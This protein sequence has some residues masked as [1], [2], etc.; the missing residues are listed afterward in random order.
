[1][2][3]NQKSRG[4][5]PF[6]IVAASL[7]IL[8][9]APILAG[10]V[11]ELVWAF[12]VPPSRP[13]AGTLVAG[14]DGYFWGTTEEGGARGQGT[15]YKVRADGSDWRSIVSFDYNNPNHRGYDPR[16][17]LMSD[18]VDFLWGTTN[19]GGANDSGTIFKVRAS[20]GELIKVLD[21][22]R[23]GPTNTGA[24]C[25]AELYN[26]GA[27]YF[28]GTTREG[29]A[30][31]DGTIFKVNANTGLLTNLVQ[32]NRN[33]AIHNGA[34]PRA[35]LVS[36]GAGYLW[37]T[38]TLG[39][40]FNAGTVFK[41]N[42]STGILTTAV[43]FSG[44]GATN[45]GRI[46]IAGLI[47]DGAGFLWGTTT[48]GG[49]NEMGT[50]FKVNASTGA[51]STVAEF[52]PPLGAPNIAPQPN[53]RLI[54][55]GAGWFR[56]TTT[57][58]G[59]LALGTLFAVNATTGELA[60]LFEFTGEGLANRGSRP[61][62][63]LVSVG[64]GS[65]LGTTQ[66]GGAHG[67]GTVFRVEQSTGALTTLLE[68]NDAGRTVKGDSPYVGLIN[69]GAGSLWGTT[70]LGG[71]G[72]GTIF[73]V[74]EATGEVRTVV[75][76]TG[77]G[78]ANRGSEP[79]AMLVG[80]GAGYLWGTTSE[81]G[82]SESG[83]IFKIHASTGLMTTVLEFTGNGPANRG[84]RP[85]GELAG[86]GMGFFW[87]TTFTGGANGSGTVF[88]VHAISGTLSTL[89]D[90]NNA[91]GNNR[92][93]EPYAG[94]VHDDL[95]FFWGTTNRGGVSNEGTIFKVNANTGAITTVVD[96]TGNG[97]ILKGGEPR[98][99]LASDGLGFFWGTTSEGGASD[100]GT[101]FKV[102][103]STGE[104]S[105]VVEFT[106]MNGVA[107][108]GEP[109]AG[110]IGD[111]AGFLWGTTWKGG[112][113]D[114]GTV[115][116]VNVV[117]GAFTTVVELTGSG[118]QANSGY[119]PGYGS[120]LRHSD[121]SFYGTTQA[122]GPENGGTVFRLRFGP[123]PV[124]LAA[125]VLGATTATLHGTINPNGNF[126]TAWFE[127]GTNPVLAT[128][129]TV[130]AGTTTNGTIPEA[131]STLL[132]GLS[133]GITYYYRVVGGN[134]ENAQPQ[135]G[136]IRSFTLPGI[137]PLQ[138]WR[139][140]HF[141]TTANVGAAANLADWDGDNVT[142]LIEFALGM[143]P[144]QNST[145]L[146]PTGKVI[147]GDFVLTVIQPPGVNGIIYGAEW[148]TTLLPASWFPASNTA[149]PPQYT[150]RLPIGAAGKGFL[151]LKVT[152]Q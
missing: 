146:L 128:F 152:A 52:I 25:R 70:Q 19:R 81:G 51:L 28:W 85:I 60:T 15:V 95:G 132:S 98:A 17:A 136:A 43:E 66:L 6:F 5:V 2:K 29:G 107:K 149:T 125:D 93:S 116:K 8:F 138:A 82:A 102:N 35:G 86:D 68:F 63:G 139:L 75:E 74:I 26:D 13:S 67:N 22:N 121:G 126:S 113:H 114:S 91:I 133:S 124:T 14:P 129:F 54:S 103:A 71:R 145:G 24:H 109:R 23:N 38:T 30:S 12:G 53:A 101:V 56:G 9:Q 84:A 72:Y 61:L 50:V 73:K 115:F 57:W 134:A 83:T 119:L 122:G 10:P 48:S 148:S 42:A 117:S 64:D 100:L 49:T 104:M 32:F 94:L 46:P 118:N 33:E 36:D 112:S 40:A 120:L 78:P 111:A 55:D 7:F 108:G 41:V 58:G 143:N 44:N 4:L 135:R 18:G 99:K 105:T 11:H 3:P 76:F 45:K 140:A 141:G 127:L 137:T 97:A 31:N 89:V 69:D 62:A 21:F 90:F 1:M 16:A 144:H 142:N 92:G 147:G 88:K 77:D 87:G 27:G 131:V 34:E 65:F 106:G 59:A 96:F 123:G 37:G 110:L 130:A 150:F 20:D 80:D 47:S 151:R 39:G 79:R